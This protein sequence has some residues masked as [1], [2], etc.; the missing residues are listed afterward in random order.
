MKRFYINSIPRESIGFGIRIISVFLIAL[1][2]ITGCDGDTDIIP[3]EKQPPSIPST[4]FPPDGADDLSLDLRISW[5]CS[6]I[7][8]DTLVYDLYFGNESDPPLFSAEQR[9]YSYRF[10]GYDTSSALELDATYYWKVIAKERVIARIDSVRGYDEED[11]DSIWVYETDTT[12]GESAVSEIWNFSTSKLYLDTLHMIYNTGIGTVPGN[13]NKV[14]VEGDNDSLIYIA[15]DNF[16]L[17]IVH[18]IDTTIMFGATD[19]IDI[20][21]IQ[22][23]GEYEELI[24]QA[25]VKDITV[26]GNYAYLSGPGVIIVDITDAEN[27][28]STFYSDTTCYDPTSDNG[29]DI[30]CASAVSDDE[31]YVFSINGDSLFA[32]DVSNSATIDSPIVVGSWPTPGTAKDIYYSGDYVYIADSLSGLQIVDISDPASPT[33]TG[34]YSYS[35]TDAAMG[36]FVDGNTAYLAYG[37]AGLVMV[38]VASP[39]NPS[40]IGSPITLIGEDETGFAKDVYVQDGYA[41]IAAYW[42]GGLQIVDIAEASVVAKYYTKGG[43]SGVFAND[44]Y[45]YLADRWPGLLVFEFKH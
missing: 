4:P 26:V 22:Q 21:T 32:I 38:N 27:P 41:Y 9:N 23:V 17:R 35:E 14:F 39:A 7:D 29:D 18:V 45:V 10:Y 40:I 5:V 2:A 15:D 33:L 34:N 43:A 6:D 25:D 36:V 1:F 16:G 31:L 20:K 42:N 19:S 24:F 3:V 12:W 11:E 13:V 44:K 30:F 8:L 28:V 37:K